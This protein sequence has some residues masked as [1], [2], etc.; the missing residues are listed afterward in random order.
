MTVKLKDT[1]YIEDVRAAVGMAASMLNSM[2][3]SDH[4]VVYDTITAVNTLLKDALAK[5]EGKGG[6]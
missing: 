5:L 2:S 3:L 4:L 6:G 1:A